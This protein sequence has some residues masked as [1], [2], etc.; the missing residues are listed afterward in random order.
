MF[1]SHASL[2]M[3]NVILFFFFS[4][5]CCV[6][7]IRKAADIQDDATIFFFIIIISPF[8]TTSYSHPSCCVFLFFFFSGKRRKKKKK[9]EEEAQQTSIK[10]PDVLAVDIQ[11]HN[12]QIFLFIPHIS[13]DFLTIPIHA[14]AKLFV[15]EKKIGGKNISDLISIKF[16][17]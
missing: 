2:P 1:E 16:R 6:F 12:K 5:P 3:R 8:S 11:T 9:W 4:F 14:N 17:V 10:L 7:I 15:N 13:F